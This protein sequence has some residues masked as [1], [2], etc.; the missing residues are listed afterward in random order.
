MLITTLSQVTIA[1]QMWDL[2]DLS[3]LKATPIQN[4]RVNKKDVGDFQKILDNL[5]IKG[6]VTESMENPKWLMIAGKFSFSDLMHV[7]EVI[8]YARISLEKPFEGFTV[9]SML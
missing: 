4:V 9:E 5:S 7:L 2:K 8:K 3:S 1:K 6:K